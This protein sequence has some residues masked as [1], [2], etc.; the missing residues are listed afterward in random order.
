[1]SDKYTLEKIMKLLD[2][3]EIARVVS[4]RNWVAREAFSLK[5]NTVKDYEELVS[6]LIRYIQHH[7]MR[8]LAPTEFP[9]NISLGRVTEFLR[10]RNLTLK[11]IY[12]DCRL[13]T[14]GGVRRIIDI[15]A[16]GIDQEHV[17]AY[18]NHILETEVPPFD[19]EFIEG[20]MRA[21]VGKYGQDMPF[22][23]RSIPLMMMDWRIVLTETAKA[24][25]R[26]RTH[27][28]PA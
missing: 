5:K 28:A 18:V 21:F 7:S 22:A 24:Q 20:L 8:V 3:A 4:N 13:G 6:L 15:L 9:A 27:I 17:Q 16:E 26:L 12:D 25:A 10:R 1:M 23:G 2:P 19:F 11:E 14:N